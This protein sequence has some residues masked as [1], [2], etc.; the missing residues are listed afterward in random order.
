MFLLFTQMSLA[1]T[2]VHLD[3][4]W[5]VLLESFVAIHAVFVAVN[6]TIFFGGPDMWPM[7]FSGFAFMFVFTYLYAFRQTRW[8]YGAV[9]V[10]YVAFLVWLYAPFGY[11]R[12]FS[13]A[14]RFEA[15]WIPIILYGL[16]IAF[17]GVAYLKIRK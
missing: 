11:A 17:A 15:L 16:T 8:V 12:G 5:I 3:K 6:N 13:I 10:I 1:Y 2:W 14:L 7:F 4:R 9:T